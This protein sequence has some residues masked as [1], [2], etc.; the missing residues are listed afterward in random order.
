MKK[1]DSTIDFN[2]KEHIALKAS[3]IVFFIFSFV[4]EFMFPRTNRLLYYKIPNILAMLGLTTSFIMN[5]KRT[6]SKTSRNIAIL[7]FVLFLLN[8]KLWIDDI[9]RNAEIINAVGLLN[10]MNI[11]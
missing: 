10:M 7:F 8:I 1:W 3:V 2:S 4:I 6:K 11:I 9:N 5:F